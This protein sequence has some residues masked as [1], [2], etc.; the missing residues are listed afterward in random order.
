[1]HDEIGYLCDTC[2]EEIMIPVDASAGK[3]QSFVE[4][5]PV[6]CR[7]HVVHIEID[8]EGDVRA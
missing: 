2:G 6:C 5:C 3:S 8:S 4:D 7:P 1:M